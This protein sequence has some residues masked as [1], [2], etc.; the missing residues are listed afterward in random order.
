MKKPRG[1]T[2][3]ELMIVVAIVAILAAIALPSY[4]QYIVRGKMTEAYSNLLAMRVQ[5]EQ[6]YQDNRSY[7][8]FPCLQPPS[9]KYFTYLCPNPAQA[10][11]TITATGAVGTD[12]DGMIFSIDQNN[13]RATVVNAPASAN[14]CAGNAG[15]WIIRKGGTC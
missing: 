10:T 1:F 13:N 3:I 2:L 4:N 5:A 15:C 9:A 7:A 12:V 11:Y 6:F 14:G 8:G